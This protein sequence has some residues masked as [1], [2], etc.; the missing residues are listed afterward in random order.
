MCVECRYS[1]QINTLHWSELQPY[2]RS[3]HYCFNDW[4]PSMNLRERY[5]VE[6]HIE[7]EWML[8]VLKVPQHSLPRLQGGDGAQRLV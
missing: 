4:N 8:D 2:N 3:L 7:H 5:S 1:Y 6:N